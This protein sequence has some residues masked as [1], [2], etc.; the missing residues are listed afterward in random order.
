MVLAGWWAG[1]ISLNDDSQKKFDIVWQPQFYG[2][3]RVTGREALSRILRAVYVP[4]KYAPRPVQTKKSDSSA[5]A[6]SYALKTEFVRRIAYRAEIGP[7]E[8]PRKCWNTRKV[9]LRPREHV[10]AL[11]WMHRVGLGG[12]LFLHGMRMTRTG[13]SVALVRIKKLE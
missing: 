2:F 1:D 10:R 9:S 7:P 4:T 13:N 6:I 11:L 8:N 3:A 5:E 12:R